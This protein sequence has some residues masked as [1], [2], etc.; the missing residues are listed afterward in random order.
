MLMRKLVYVVLLIILRT[1]KEIYQ[2]G[3]VSTEDIQQLQKDSTSSIMV[4]DDK[5]A[6]PH[7]LSLIHIY[8]TINNEWCQPELITKIPPVYRDGDLFD[9]IA[10]SSANEFKERCINQYKQYIAHNNTQSQF[11]EDTRTPVS[12]THLDV[13]KRQPLN[14][15]PKYVSSS[16]F[17]IS[18]SFKKTGS[19]FL[20]LGPVIL[21]NGSLVTSPCLKRYL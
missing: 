21:H 9:S 1:L 8:A 7:P 2:A 5:L 3:I 18:L 4:I 15:Y 16:S 14:P 6:N 19:G 11:S 20:F 17:F 13:Y 12:Y 10:G